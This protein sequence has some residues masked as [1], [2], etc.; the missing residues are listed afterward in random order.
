MRKI[1]IAMMVLGISQ[2]ALAFD[3]GSAVKSVT[4][5]AKDIDCANQALE[6]VKEGGEKALE[7]FAQVEAGGAITMPGLEENAQLISNTKN[8]VTNGCA[9]SHLEKALAMVNSATSVQ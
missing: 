1:L 9:K 3:L 5:G 8:Y 2:S 7:L 6:I 4:G